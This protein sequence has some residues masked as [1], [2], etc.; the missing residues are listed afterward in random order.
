MIG[1]FHLVQGHNWS[2]FDAYA[3]LAIDIHVQYA[4]GAWVPP[5]YNVSS[6]YNFEYLYNGTNI[7]VLNISG[8]SANILSDPVVILVTYEEWNLLTEGQWSRTSG[9]RKILKHIYEIEMIFEERG[10]GI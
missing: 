5:N 8:N 2:S 6:G 9:R 3:V 4:S 1:D 7:Y 10:S